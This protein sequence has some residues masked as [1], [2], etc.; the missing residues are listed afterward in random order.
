MAYQT[1]D[2]AKLATGEPTSQ[3][4]FRRTRDN[5][6]DHEDRLNAI[7]LTANKFAPIEFE[8]V[9]PIGVTQVQD[10]LLFTRIPLDIRIL[11]V[12]MI[13]KTAGIGGAHTVDLKYKRG[14]DPWATLLFAPMQI[15][16]SAGD[17][18]VFSGN[19]SVAELDLNDYL[20]MDISTVQQRGNGLLVQL[21]Y[22]GR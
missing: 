2:L 6:E 19:V 4:L 15:S 22:E 9:G 11:A 18:A 8:V 3:E 7:E 12:R 10:S 16:F 5:F 21:E 20:R 17:L 13:A 14:T 1:I